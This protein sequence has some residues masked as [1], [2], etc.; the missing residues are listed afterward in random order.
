[1]N[2]PLKRKVAQSQHRALGYRARASAGYPGAIRLHQAVGL[3]PDLHM[4]QVRMFA[5]GVGRT[6]SGFPTTNLSWTWQ[7]PTEEGSPLLHGALAAGL[8][9]GQQGFSRLLNLSAW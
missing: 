9:M 4:V 1:M 7:V 6:A 8:C 5:C 2:S 3:A